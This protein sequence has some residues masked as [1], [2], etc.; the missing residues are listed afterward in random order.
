[1][2]ISGNAATKSSADRQ[3]PYIGKQQLLKSLNTFLNCLNDLPDAS[4]FNT[5]TSNMKKRIE[6]LVKNEYGIEKPST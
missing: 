6:Q 5:L 3:L 2:E 1:M 4:Q